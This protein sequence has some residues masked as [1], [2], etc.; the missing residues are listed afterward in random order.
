[1]DKKGPDFRSLLLCVTDCR[2]WE[3]ESAGPQ[4]G[5]TPHITP[6]RKRA[7]LNTLP[8]CANG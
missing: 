2:A 5:K 6:L 4:T 1:M 8:L 7:E 3:G